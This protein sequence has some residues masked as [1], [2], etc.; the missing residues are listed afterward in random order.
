MFLSKDITYEKHVYYL[1][2]KPKGVVSAAT[3][4]LNKT[5]IDLIDDTDKRKNLFPVGRL[6]KDTEGLLIITNDGAFSHN[7]LS[8]SKH[9]DKTYFAILK[10]HVTNE[11]IKA[12]ADGID[13]GTLENPEPCK[14]AKLEI[15]NYNDSDDTTEVYIT[16]SEGKFHQ[17]KRMAYKIGC[18]VTYL[19]R[20]SMGSFTLP[21]DL[22]LG[23]YIKLNIQKS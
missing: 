13:I 6:D 2:N 3:D 14:S 11:D 22:P 5:V 8:P 19:K 18:T 12:F 7:L 10:G 1:L 17:V 21:K 23:K 20:I 16:I 15:I 9:V 4:N